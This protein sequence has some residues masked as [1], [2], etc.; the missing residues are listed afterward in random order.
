[1]RHCGVES[2]WKGLA[3]PFGLRLAL[4]HLGGSE[5]INTMLTEYQRLISE[6][7]RF[8]TLLTDSL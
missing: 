6:H 5:Y 2:P 3:I 8:E 7:F 1:M 4:T